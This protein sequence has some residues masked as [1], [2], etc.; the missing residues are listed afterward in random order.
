ML[1]RLSGGFSEAYLLH[2]CYFAQNNGSDKKKINL[3]L[4][5]PRKTG[6]WRIAT[7]YA[8]P[9]GKNGTGKMVTN[10]PR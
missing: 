3:T 2:H 5:V 8:G 7:K 6:V 1:G 9:Y 4:M 10:A